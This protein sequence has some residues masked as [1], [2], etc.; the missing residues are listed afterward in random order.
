MEDLSLV[1]LTKREPLCHSLLLMQCWSRLM[2]L[3]SSLISFFLFSQVMIFISLWLRQS[4][5]FK[6]IL[7]IQIKLHYIV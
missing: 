4:G 2:L 3:V 1:R 7:L 5:Y 6:L